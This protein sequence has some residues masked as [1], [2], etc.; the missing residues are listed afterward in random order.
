[1]TSKSYESGIQPYRIEF[2][3]ESS[4]GVTPSDPSWNLFSDNV[5]TF[6]PA[7]DPQTEGQQGLGDPD[8][9]GS[10]AG[11]EQTEITVM[12]DLQQWLIDGSSNAQDASY[13]AVARNSDNRIPNSH[14]VVRRL[15]VGSLDAGNTINGSNSKDSRLYFVGKGG[16]ADATFTMNIDSGQPIQVELAYQFEK[17]RLYQIDQPPSDGTGKQ[18]AFKTSADDTNDQ[19]TTITVQGVDDSDNAAEEDV[20]LDGTNSTTLVDTDTQFQEI[21]AIEIGSEL[22]N[23][24]E[25]YEDDDN[26]NDSVTQGD[27]LA[28]FYGQSSYDQGEGDLGVPALGTGSHASSLGSSYELPLDGDLFELPSGTTIADEITTTEISFENNIEP[29]ATDNGPRPALSEGGRNAEVS[30]T[31][32]GQVE[33]YQHTVDMLRTS[34]QDYKWTASSPS[35]DTGSITLSGTEVTEVG[36]AEE[37]RQDVIEVDLTVGQQEGVT[38]A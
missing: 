16:L 20:S 10:F 23:D 9:A 25:V 13:D 27:Q 33:T 15:D 37:A 30:T 5:R 35:G 3:R 26:T 14:T 28:V 11:T 29:R 12:Y 7:I 2:I 24:L 8:Y 21:D 19:G 22:V 6:E 1:M 38:V 17:G 18:I 4:R 34:S 36:Q 32:F 31:V